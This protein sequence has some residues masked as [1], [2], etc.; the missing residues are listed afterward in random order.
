[1]D[2]DYIEYSSRH[3]D[4]YG[5]V[6]LYWILIIIFAII[7]SCV[8]G[9]AVQ[10]IIYN[11]GYTDDWFWWGFFFGIIAL[12]AAL[13]RPDNS[14]RYTTFV[15]SKNEETDMLSRGGWK[16]NNCNRVLANYVGSCSCGNTRANNVKKEK[17]GVVNS[18]SVSN[19]LREYKSLLDSGIITQEEFDTKKKQLLGL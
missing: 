10:K 8:W 3:S 5:D 14:N 7:I 2:Y 17:E 15:H 13:S 6:I 18:T 4:G 12:L 1:M 16:C 11:K 9:Y 19:E